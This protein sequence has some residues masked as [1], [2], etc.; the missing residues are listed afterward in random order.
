MTTIHTTN[1]YYTCILFVV[2]TMDAYYIAHLRDAVRKVLSQIP[3]SL[4]DLKQ[5]EYYDSNQYKLFCSLC[6]VTLAV[7]C[8]SSMADEV[9]LRCSPTDVHRRRLLRTNE[10]DKLTEIVATEVVKRSD[11]S[12]LELG[13][14]YKLVVPSSVSRFFL[15]RIRCRCLKSFNLF[16]LP[17]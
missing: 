13:L 4:D 8:V 15:Y 12:H 7:V 14:P 17:V 3:C 5:L 2:L 10:I 6:G 16:Y 1:L 11:G 9:C